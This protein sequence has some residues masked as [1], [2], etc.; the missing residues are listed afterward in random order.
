MPKPRAGADPV[1]V[2]DPQVTKTHVLGVIVVRKRKAELR[3][4]PPVVGV[5]PFCRWPD[6]DHV[7]FAPHRLD[8]AG[9]E[10]YASVLQHITL[11]TRVFG[12]EFGV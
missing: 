3:V 9:S 6:G 1:F 11:K 10:K 8:A 4:E 2:D 7:F 12:D 5:A